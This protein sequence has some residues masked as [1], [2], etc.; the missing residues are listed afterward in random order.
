MP[1]CGAV[2]LEFAAVSQRRNSYPTSMDCPLSCKYAIRRDR[3]SGRR[4]SSG[5]LSQHLCRPTVAIEGTS[6]AG[7]AAFDEVT[8]RS[9]GGDIQRLEVFTEIDNVP[10]V[11]ESTGDLD[12]MLR[13]TEL[14]G[15]TL[16]FYDGS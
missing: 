2:R 8:R 11:K 1:S 12:R 16:P 6:D 3:G 13:I 9:G 10:M 14:T 4:E 7:F 15:N 5:R